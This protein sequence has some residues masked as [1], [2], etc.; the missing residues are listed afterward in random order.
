MKIKFYIITYNNNEILNSWILKSLYESDYN[1]DNV[2]IFIINNHSNIKIDDTYKS[3][4]TVLNNNLRPDFSTGHLSRNYNQAI[5]NG[6]KDL[7]SPDCDIVITCQND[8]FLL[9]NWY[10]SIMDIMDKYTYFTYGYGDQ[11]Q[12]WKVDGI[13]NIGLYDERFCNIGFQEADYFLRSFIYNKNFSSVNDFHHGRLINNFQPPD[14]CKMILDYTYL[15]GAAREDESHKKSQSYHGLSISL[16]FHKWGNDIKPQFWN[17]C[18][19][20]SKLDSCK[21]LNYILYPYFEKKILNLKEK[22]YFVENL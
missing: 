7:D 8:T 5:I 14:K 15:P 1:R 19:E 3:F 18:P 10:S 22:Q 20:L 2:Q 12:A 21:I 6:F 16:F 13:K 4:V 11:F 9:K 17:E